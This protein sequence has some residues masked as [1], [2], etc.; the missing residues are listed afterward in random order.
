MAAKFDIRSIILE[1]NTVFDMQTAKL[2]RFIKNSHKNIFMM[3]RSSLASGQIFDTRSG[4][5][6]L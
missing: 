3:K 2:D 6:T 4:Y 1:P 5:Q